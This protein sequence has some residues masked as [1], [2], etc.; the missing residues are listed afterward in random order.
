MNQDLGF[1]PDPEVVADPHG[2]GFL[3]DGESGNAVVNAVKTGA[4]AIGKGADYQRGVVGLGLDQLGGPSAL[5]EGTTPADIL[6]LKNSKT[7]PSWRQGL[8]TKGVPAGPSLPDAVTSSMSPLQMLSPS[9]AKMVASHLP[10]WT[11][12]DAAGTALD[13]AS[14][15]VTYEGGAL[16]KIGGLLKDV[17]YVGDGL[18]AAA[19]LSSGLSYVLKRGATSLYESGIRPIIQAGERFGNPNVGKTMLSEGI[20]GSPKAIQAGMEQSA[21]RLAGEVDQIHQA[22]EAAGAEAST[23][24]AYDIP[25]QFLQKLVTERR[26][27]PEDARALFN[28]ITESKQAGPDGVTSRLM[29]TWK[30]DAANALPGNTWDNLS[31]VNPTLANQVKQSAR[32]GLQNETEQSIARVL[33]DQLGPLQ[34][35]NRQWGDLI[36]DDVRKAAQGMVD[37]HE[38]KPFLSTSDLLFG[39]LGMGGGGMVNPGHTVESGA[40]IVALKKLIEGARSTAFKTSVGNFGDKFLNTILVS[41]LLDAASRRAIVDTTRK[42]PYVVPS[43]QKGE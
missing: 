7:F 26:M 6:S 27:T 15:P 37:R 18:N 5:P 20:S 13:I 42:S 10:N 12:R 30:T 33:P 32:K 24:A 19:H 36:N 17:P 34:T 35:K 39:A 3:P 25:D 40:A 1:S 43:P 23:S 22:G 29:N 41:P 16:S 21:K 2:V 31:K 38:S 28:Q 9:T 11:A 8:E 4:R 14:D